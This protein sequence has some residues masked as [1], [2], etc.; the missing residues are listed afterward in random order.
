MI[1]LGDL[2]GFVMI[3]SL[4]LYA[5]GAGADFGG[6]VWDLSPVGRERAASAN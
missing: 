1:S 4:I 5:L 6:G 3:I 2:V